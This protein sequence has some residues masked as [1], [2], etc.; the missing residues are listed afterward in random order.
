[1]LTFNAISCLRQY[2]KKNK[3]KERQIRSI[4][5]RIA[6]VIIVISPLKLEH[7][8]GLQQHCS[9]IRLLI[10]IRFFWMIT[11]ILVHGVYS[12]CVAHNANLISK[13]QHVWNLSRKCKKSMHPSNIAI[14]KLQDRVSST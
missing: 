2:V 5:E 6:Q 14:L 8:I 7:K 11:P 10:K 4:E 3:E 12:S 13:I 9:D 1:M